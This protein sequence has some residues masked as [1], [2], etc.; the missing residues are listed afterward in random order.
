M[1]SEILIRAHIR[2]LR[3]NGR[4]QP[5]LHSVHT[6]LRA[7][8]FVFLDGQDPS[9]KSLFCNVLCGIVPLFDPAELDGEVYFEDRNL[10][11]LRLPE[12]AGRVGLV[13]EEADHQLV[14]TTVEEDLAFGPCNL[15]LKPTEIRAR[16]R[17]ALELVGLEGFEERRPE[18]LSGGESQRMTLAAMLTLQPRVLILDRCMHQVDPQ[19][20]ATLYSKLKDWCRQTGRAVLFVDE[21][22]PEHFTLPNRRIILAHG[23]VAHDGPP[24]RRP[25]GPSGA[26]FPS[27]SKR[28]VSRGPLKEAGATGERQGGFHPDPPLPDR[29]DVRQTTVLRMN[30][31]FYRY[32]GSVFGLED[33][34]LD[35]R[36]GE[37]VAV[38][39]S[40][41]AGKTTLVKLIGGF[42]RPDGGKLQVCSLDTRSHSPAHLA[43]HV[44]I[45]FQDP[46]LRICTTSVWEETAFGLRVRKV[47]RREITDRVAHVL[48]R[49][50]LSHR[51]NMH[52]LRLT[53]GE[54]QRLAL[55][56][57]LV[58]EPEILLL[59]EPTS[60]LSALEKWEVLRLI[61]EENRKGVT[62][63]VIT[64]DPSAT[65]LLCR[66]RV[67]I[68][69]GR[70]FEDADISESCTPSPCGPDHGPSPEKPFS[71][72]SPE[73]FRG[74]LP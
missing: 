64:H 14:C 23:T 1:S 43:R 47:P 9:L 27:Y 63:V 46:G 41:G 13:R 50:Q 21:H 17:W 40:N 30:N 55:A 7:G 57:A 69:H 6:D 12:L 28:A 33:V 37:C 22:A 52:P 39:G 20:R 74:E 51:S 11:E 53:P 24:I 3:V 49:F 71:P 66:R 32:P 58:T 73:E 44:G 45:C 2:T 25:A 62:V 16:I 60:R 26:D 65:A 48:D 56:S 4:K 42:L 15:L 61:R 67:I 5:L 18:Q 54:L 29:D 35:I 68:S 10:A 38:Q 70:I 31:V 19:G 59:D 34:S 8:E 36:S 72:V